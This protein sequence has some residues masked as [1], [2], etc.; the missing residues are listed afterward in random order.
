MLCAAVLG[1]FISYM[2]VMASFYNVPTNRKLLVLENVDF[3]VTNFTYFNVTILNPSNSA[4]DA[5]ITAFRVSVEGK[6]QTYEVTATEYPQP[7]SY[8]LRRGTR[9]TFKCIQNWS[10]FTGE[11]VKIEPIAEGFSTITD[12]HTAPNVRLNLT[13][14]F[15]STESVEYFN[16]LVNSGD[17]TANLTITE[18]RIFSEQL[19]VTPSLGEGYLFLPNRT[20]LFRCDRNWDNLRG[21]NVTITLKTKEGYEASYET[22]KL[23]GAFLFI[24]EIKFD[25]ADTTY[26]NVTVSNAEDSTDRIILDKVNMTLPD[27]STI[28]LPTNPQLDLPIPISILPNTSQ[29]I[30]CRWSWD[31]YRSQNIT[32]IVYTKQG[33]SPANMTE[34]T[35]SDLMWNITDVGFDLDDSNHFSVNITNMPNSRRNVNVT[36]IQLNSQNVTSM[37]PPYAVVTNGTQATFSCTFNWTTLKGANIT[38]TALT[39]DRLNISESLTIPAVK[40]E[41]LGDRF[42]YGDIDTIYGQVFNIT[43]PPNMSIPRPPFVNVT[44]LN[45]V[46]SIRNVTITKI[47]IETN[48]TT[49]EIDNTL[50]S[51]RLGQSGYLLT[52]GTNASIICI[53]DYVDRLNLARVKVTVYTA[54]GFQASKTWTQ[55]SP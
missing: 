14:V 25:Y 45:S 46:N 35:P 54:E 36:M 48:Y 49:Y 19:N 26:F 12:P 42:V 15:N 38:V 22:E 41:I 23:L 11:A 17:S 2:W 9:Q 16:L 31:T 7:L 28:T 30:M 51:P 32:V 5:N 21:Q 18:M 55:Y 13:P 52:I 29:S 53:W 3:S 40:L 43:I 27:N 37:T 20:Q 8:V 24:N 34:T 39:T 50:T 10:N 6:N 44:I 4:S 47:T 33:L 1:A